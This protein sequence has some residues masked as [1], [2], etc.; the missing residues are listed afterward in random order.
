LGQILAIEKST[1][2]LA[3]SFNSGYVI[4]AIYREPKEQFFFFLALIGNS[5]L[6][7]KRHVT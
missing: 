1:L 2:I 3:I 7:W 4:L 5:Y 6:L